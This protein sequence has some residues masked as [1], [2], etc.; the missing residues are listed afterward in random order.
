M[1]VGL[2]STVPFTP[3]WIAHGLF[4]AHQH[5]CLYGWL[6]VRVHRSAVYVRLHAHAVRAPYVYH[7]RSHPPLPHIPH[8]WLLPAHARQHTHRLV[9]TRF[10]ATPVLRSATRWIMPSLVHGCHIHA[11]CGCFAGWLPVWLRCCHTHIPHT[12]FC[13]GCCGLRYR[14]ISLHRYLRLV[15][16][17]THSCCTVYTVA[18]YLCIFPY[19]VFYFLLWF[20]DYAHTVRLHTHLPEPWITVTFDFT[21]RF[22]CHTLLLH[23]TTAHTFPDSHAHLVHTL[24]SSHGWLPTHI[25]TPR[26]TFTTLRCAVG[27]GCLVTLRCW[28]GCTPHTFYGCAYRGCCGSRFTVLRYGFSSSHRFTAYTILHWLPGL[29]VTFSCHYTLY[30]LVTHCHPRFAVHARSSS[31]CTYRHTYI[32]APT[33]GAVRF[34]RIIYIHIYIPAVTLFGLHPIQ[35]IYFGLRFLW[36]RLRQQHAGI[37]LSFSPPPHAVTRSTIPALRA[38]SPYGCRLRILPP[39]SR[40]FR[41][42]AVTGL[43]APMRAFTTARLLRLPTRWCRA[44][45]RLGC[46]SFGSGLRGS[47]SRLPRLWLPFGL[48]L[49]PVAVAFLVGY[50]WFTGLLP[51]LVGLR[52]WLYGLVVA[53][54]LVRAYA[55]AHYAH[56]WF[57]CRFTRFTPCHHHTVTRGLRF[58]ACHTG[59]RTPRLRAVP[60]SPFTFTRCRLFQLPA[61]ALLL[62]ILVTHTFIPR[63]HGFPFACPRS[64]ILR[65]LVYLRARFIPV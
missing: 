9:Y 35:F 12:P 43:I 36:L 2:R 64:W 39:R 54:R 24:G 1:L 22:T 65:W 62:L 3:F 60:D 21:H 48:P 26:S 6:L 23:A 7:D 29:P 58:H 19:T 17:C 61:V 8:G 49:Y 59:L 56:G 42:V 34:Y 33:H 27:L 20:P 52:S 38:F 51:G 55:H 40:L 57:G 15:Y 4:Y 25:H 16:V 30:G 10:T 32:L 47:D 45:L 46:G 13:S 44:F 31:V 63:T 14:H 18:I 53:A 37:V 41:S 5:V 50:V 11:A 28:F